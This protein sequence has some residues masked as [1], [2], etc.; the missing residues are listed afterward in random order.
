LPI[1]RSALTVGKSNGDKSSTFHDP[2]QGVPHEG[3]ELEEGV[4]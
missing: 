3:E 1:R 2:R 4:F